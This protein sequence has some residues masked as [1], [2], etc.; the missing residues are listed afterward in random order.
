MHIKLK[1]GQSVRSGQM[2]NAVK[3]IQTQLELFELTLCKQKLLHAFYLDWEKV[4][5]K[6]KFRENT[7]LFCLPVI[8]LSQHMKSTN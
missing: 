4:E 8:K 3:G 2:R 5:G 6:V 7:F 1:D